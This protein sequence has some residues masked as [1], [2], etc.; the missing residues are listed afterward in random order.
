MIRCSPRQCPGP[1][2]V[3]HLHNDIH[4]P[5]ENSFGY[6]FADDTKLVKSILDSLDYD[7]MQDDLDVWCEEWKIFL[8]AKKCS[9]M[10]FTLNKSG[11]CHNYHTGNC[12]IASVET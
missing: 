6:S 2:V 5:V 9:H 12:L 3:S 7:L 11:S 4:T 8:N 10:H 1:I